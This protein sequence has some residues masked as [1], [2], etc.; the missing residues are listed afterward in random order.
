MPPGGR[1][2]GE[3]GLLSPLDMVRTVAYSPPPRM[4]KILKSFDESSPLHVVRHFSFL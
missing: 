3:G 4:M 1:T 2:P